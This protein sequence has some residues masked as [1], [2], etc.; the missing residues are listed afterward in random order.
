MLDWIRDHPGLLAAIAVASVVMFVGSLIVVPIIAARIPADYF[1]HDRRPPSALRRQHPV[2]RAV[3]LIGKNLL[4]IALIFAGLAMLVLPGQGLLTIAMGLV[5]VDAPG[6]Y[7]LERRLV[8][9]KWVARPINWLRRT[10]GR[11][12]L[13]THSSGG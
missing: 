2:L 7:V 4:G 9:M 1:A 10:R 6:K 3:G 13:T 5:L 8:A 11:E 12:P